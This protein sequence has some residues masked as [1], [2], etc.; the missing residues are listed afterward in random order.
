MD[1]HPE[2]VLLWVH[3][4]DAHLPYKDGY[5]AEL[6][7]LDVAVGQLQSAMDAR[8]RE[9]LW[10]I[11]GDHGEGLSESQE[12]EHGLLVD[13][14]QMRVPWILSGPG[15]PIAQVD[16]AVGLADVLPTLLS[17]LGL[18]V[19]SGLDGAI[20]PGNPRPLILE[21]WQLTQR[22]GWQPHRALVQGSHKLS[23][24]S[25]IHI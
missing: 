4:Y 25:L 24:L 19:P 22:F 14:A 17:L 16:Q 15:V 10:V 3:L 11:V 5:N 8:A 12:P 13:E 21:S 23:V 2:P 20:Q 6:G 9:T 1:Q 7:R 18:P